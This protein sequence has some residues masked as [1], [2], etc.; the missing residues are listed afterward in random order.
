M[1]QRSKLQMLLLEVFQMLTKYSSH[2]IIE[3]VRLVRVDRKWHL[4][5]L[6]K[7]ITSPALCYRLKSNT[8]IQTSVVL[9]VVSMKFQVLAQSDENTISNLLGHIGLVAAW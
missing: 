3:L 4:T 2:R 8:S 9:V 7:A 6:V 1:Q 5:L